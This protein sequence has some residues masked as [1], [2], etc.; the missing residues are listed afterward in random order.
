M[1]AQEDA[2]GHDQDGAEA[3]K[4]AT[5]AGDSNSG[6]GW[7]SYAVSKVPSTFDMSERVYTQAD[8]TLRSESLH[9]TTGSGPP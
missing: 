6:A 4:P 1:Q 7:G 3:K 5:K 2:S 8:L 9:S